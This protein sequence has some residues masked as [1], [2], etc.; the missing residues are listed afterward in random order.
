MH[1][2]HKTLRLDEFRQQRLNKLIFDLPEAIRGALLAGI[3][4]DP[5]AWAPKCGDLLAAPLPI[6]GGVAPRPTT[7]KSARRKPSE[8]PAPRPRLVPTEGDDLPF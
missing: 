3:N 8:R 6:G 1:V 4:A 2:V 7:Q 5:V